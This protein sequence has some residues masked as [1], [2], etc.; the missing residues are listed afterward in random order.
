MHH[1]YSD[2]SNRAKRVAAIISPIVLIVVAVSV[3]NRYAADSGPAVVIGLCIVALLVVGIGGSIW[4]VRRSRR[5]AQATAREIALS[6]PD[7]VTLI[8][9]LDKVARHKLAPAS[10]R[11]GSLG[12]G[13]LVIVTINTSGIE[14]YNSSTAELL[15]NWITGSELVA[16]RPASTHR[17]NAYDEPSLRV[18]FVDGATAELVIYDSNTG[19]WPTPEV[20]AS[21]PTI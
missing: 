21:I 16:F 5:R 2:V 10:T 15:A 4:L 14:V 13:G 17:G 9:E 3:L 1:Q 20:I 8:A 11:G 6:R 19:R 7:G 12:Y 18:S